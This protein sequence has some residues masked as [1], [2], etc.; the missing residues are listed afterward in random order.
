MFLKLLSTFRWGRQKTGG[1]EEMVRGG[2]KVMWLSLHQCFSL[3]TRH[4]GGC[5]WVKMNQRHSCR[6]MNYQ[7][8]PDQS[9]VTPVCNGSETATFRLPMIV[10]STS[11]PTTDNDSIPAHPPRVCAQQ[12]TLQVPAL[13]PV[14][15]HQQ[16]YVGWTSTH[17]GG[18]R[19]GKLTGISLLNVHLCCCVFIYLSTCSSRPTYHVPTLLQKPKNRHHH[20]IIVIIII[21]II[22]VVVVVIISQNFTY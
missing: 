22:V 12:D 15:H 14:G 4:R 9:R 6:H 18:L 20:I 19:T 21:I 13:P 3:S 2:E 16:G 7:S 17:S 10:P 8:L 11:Q 5:S 1:W